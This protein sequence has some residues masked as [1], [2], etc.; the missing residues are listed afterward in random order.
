MNDPIAIQRRIENI[1]RLFVESSFPLHNKTL[2]RERHQLLKNSGVLSQPPLIEPVPIYESSGHTLDSATRLLPPE[3]AALSTLAAPL[4]PSG[5]ELYTHQLKALQASLAGRDVVVTTGTGSGK[6]ESFLLP[7]LAGLARE[8]V[9][10]SPAKAPADSRYWWRNKG[11]RVSQWAHVTRPAALRTI[12]LYPLNA[13]VEDQLTRIRSVL[14]RPDSAEW[15]EGASNGNR[16]TFGRYTGATPVAGPEDRDRTQRLREH[17]LEIDRM[18]PERE[19]LKELG[20]Q[21]EYNF[22]DLTGGEM[23]SRWDFHDSAPDILITNYSMLNIMLMRDIEQP[24]FE[25]T[26]E[27]LAASPAHRLNLVVDE[28]HSYRGTAGTEVSYILRLLL[29]RL[30]LEPDSDQLSILA[31][32][33]SIPEDDSG[34]VFLSEFF[35]RSPDRFEFI[36]NSATTPKGGNLVKFAEALKRVSQSCPPTELEG[37]RSALDI[38]VQENFRNDV[39]GSVGRSLPEVLLGMGAA[40]ALLHACTDGEGNIRATSTPELAEKLFGDKSELEPLRGLLLLLNEAKRS[41][42]QALLPVRSHMF[43]QNIHNLW[44]CSNPTC[45]DGEPDEEPTIGRLFSEHHLTCP[46]CSSRVYELIVCEVCGEVF[47][48]GRRSTP[49]NG[50]EVLSSDS[51]DLASAPDHPTGDKHATFAILAPVKSHDDAT[52][53]PKQY[54]WDKVKRRWDKSFLLNATGELVSDPSVAS[55]PGAI[56]VWVYRVASQAGTHAPAFPTRCPCCETDYGRR[57]V[58][59]TP[60]RRHGTG[61]QRSVQVLAGALLREVNERSRK[62]VAFSDSRQDAA[63]LSA[64]LE[65]DHYK[66]V[67]R[68]AALSVIR[69]G[70]VSLEG[71]A[72]HV[73]MRADEPEH[74]LSEIQRVNPLLAEA[75]RKEAK[76]SDKAHVAELRQFSPEIVKSLRLLSLGDPLE[77]DLVDALENYPHRAPLAQIVDRVFQKLATLGICPAGTTKDALHFSEGPGAPRQRWHEAYEWTDGVPK[78][79]TS[80]AAKSYNERARAL[81]RAELMQVLFTHRVRTLEGFGLGYVSAPLKN[82]SSTEQEAVDAIVRSLAVRRR[83][84]GWGRTESGTEVRLSRAIRAYLAN[85]GIDEDR[86]LRLLQGAK[87]IVPSKYGELLNPENLILV[88]PDDTTSRYACT[89][90]NAQY[91]HRAAGWC[92]HCGDGQVVESETSLEKASI[93]YYSYLAG[94]GG[95]LFRMNTEELTGQSDSSDR[96]SRQRR[97]QNVFLDGENPIAE[98]V[99]LLSVT[100]TME[101]GVDIGAL[102]AVMM[103]NMPPRRFNYQQRVGRAGRRG[104]GLSLAV[105]LCRGRTHDSYYFANP[106]AITGDPPPPPFIDTATVSIFQRVITKEALRRAF[107]SFRPLSENQKSGSESVHGNFGTATDWQSPESAWR[108]QLEA[109]LS[110]EDERAQLHSLAVHLATYTKLNSSDVDIALDSLLHLPEVISRIACEPRFTQ[111][112]ISERLANAGLLPM[113]GFPTRTRRLYLNGLPTQWPPKNVVDRDLEQ[114]ISSFAPGA[115]LVKDKLVYTVAGV[116]TVRPGGYNKTMTE[117]GLFPPIEVENP[118]PIG[119]CSSCHALTESSSLIGKAGARDHTCPTCGQP[120]VR[121]LDAREPRDFYVASSPRDYGGFFEFR[122]RTSRPMLGL[123]AEGA[124]NQVANSRVLSGNDTV[125]SLNDDDGR[126]GFTFQE[127]ARSPGAYQVEPDNTRVSYFGAPHAPITLL[128]RRTTDVLQV[129]VNSWPNGHAALPQSVEGRSAWYS[130]AF[131]LRSG[132]ARTLDIESNELDC[133]LYVAARGG[134]AEGQAF[135]CDALENGA[136]YATRFHDH[137]RFSELLSTLEHQVVADWLAHSESCDASCALCMRDYDNMAYHPILDWRLATDMIRLLSDPT[138]SLELRGGHWAP[139]VENHDSRIVRSL[140][141]LGFTSLPESTTLP[142]FTSKVKGE[143]RA[144]IVTHPLWTESHPQVVATRT[145]IAELGIANYLGE[146]SPFTLLRMPT[147]VLAMEPRGVTW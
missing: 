15:I 120:E 90:C 100:T 117:P 59:P 92:I 87:L 33:A 64:G 139:L 82:V 95:Q 141:Q 106:K 58:L 108:K 62:L 116:V 14:D 126:G 70:S 142:V 60:L 98:G 48:G 37:G 19:K 143:S 115:S 23:W 1:Y 136:G 2:E 110:R 50:V 134:T 94:P 147:T 83:F 7:V 105:T 49:L 26:R 131:A 77:D 132:A 25:A 34:R 86:M 3:Y 138:C 144:L 65:Q 146:V 5:R 112:E 97:F 71:A 109:Y 36:G 145:Q 111:E 129:G 53:E 47:L 8:M 103:G 12:V 51:Q 28:L 4:F 113:F 80:E 78:P 55:E 30:G 89:K 52:L 99:D 20:N 73:F 75:V 27:W 68:V 102:S 40:D 84:I 17:L 119:I 72:R 88:L 128:A 133:G 81:L 93:D 18:R 91:L 39:A 6:T 140:G 11:E 124:V 69:E 63:R 56:P 118:M 61:V 22:Q 127:V 43:Y 38:A 21:D 45:H 85:A 107:Q 96:T 137:D 9:T 44:A 42:G 121:V 35:G 29:N 16:I 31:T 76:P 130:L 24:M 79:G 74:F 41:D 114:A 13:L 125:L 104:A 57:T 66:D 122:G 101:A 10:W 32:S 54:E 135:L 123:S 67:V 46:Y